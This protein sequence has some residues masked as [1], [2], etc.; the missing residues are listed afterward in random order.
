MTIPEIANPEV[1]P[2]Q[3]MQWKNIYA[4][5][6]EN[7]LPHALLITGKAGLGKNAF[8]MAL[9]KLSLCNRPVDDQPC[10]TCQSCNL[11][12]AGTHP[13]LHIIEPEEEGKDIKV[14]Q[15]RDL[16]EKNSLT[17]HIAS[18]KVYSIFTAEKMTR[19]AANSLLKTLEEPASSSL[20]LLVSEH[21]EKL[22]AT[23][24]SRCQQ[25]SFSV[26]ETKMSIQ[27]LNKEKVKHDP[28]L[29]ISL[30]QGLPLTAKSF[31]NSDIL[32]LRDSVFT[33]FGKVVFGKTDPVEVAQKWHEQDFRQL[34]KWMIIW[35]SDMVKL[36]YNET[37]RIENSDKL[38]GLIKI[39][40]A[41][42]LQQLFEIYTRQINAEKLLD[43]QINRVLLIESLLMPLVTTTR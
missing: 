1:Y 7:R 4:A 3:L 28:A 9:A 41:F 17:S 6:E 19:S 25:I 24:R 16:I 30:A 22:P 37:D 2:W 42:S 20:I 5:I 33:D 27:W 32:Q 40:D 21:P 15:I 39:S 14:D 35:V 18:I 29:L 31:D 38:K 10:G 12:G 8:S 36:K 11:F 34:L 26:P 13:D 23:V 43:T